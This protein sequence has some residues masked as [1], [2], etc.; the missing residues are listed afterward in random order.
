MSL[1]SLLTD[2]VPKI[3]EVKCLAKDHTAKKG[4]KPQFMWQSGEEVGLGRMNT[5]RCMAESFAVHLKLSQ[6]LISCMPVKSS[7]N[8][9]PVFNPRHFSSGKPRCNFNR[10]ANTV[11]KGFRGHDYMSM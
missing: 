3:R 7:K 9:K 10:E 4:T 1:L 5:C 11:P 8:P 2:E 6:H